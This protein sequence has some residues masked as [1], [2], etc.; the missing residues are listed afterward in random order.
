[1]KKN[2]RYQQAKKV[3]LYGALK[4]M[5]LGLMKVILGITGN[6]HALLADG[7]HSFSDLLTD[8]LVLAAS[9]W[10][11]QEAD[12]NHPYGH[13]RIET[14]ASM[15]LAL[16]LI[17]VGF[18]IA[19]DGIIRLWE[20][21]PHELPNLYV[22]IAALVSVLLNEGLFHYT[23]HI[24]EKIQSSLLLANAWHHRSDAASSFVVL[25]GVGAALLGYYQFDFAAAAIVGLMIVR[26]GAMLAWSSV[27]EL[28][29]TAV[30][31]EKLEQIHHTISNTSGVEAI[32]QLRTRS[33]GGEIFIDVH[34]LVN[35]RLSVTEGH[36]IAQR[37][38]FN[39]V[40]KVESVKDVIVHVDPE[41]D[42]FV[43]PSLK[44]PP[45]DKL[46]EIFHQR[47]L[48][49]NAENLPFKVVFHY[50]G[51]KVYMDVYFEPADQNEVLIM[52]EYE[53]KITLLLQDFEWLGGIQ[54]YWRGQK[55]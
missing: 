49:F 48:Q 19:Y 50:L 55:F 2:H 26:M 30:E 52:E 51:G 6:S 21:L 1:M 29:D 54:C 53:E 25:A 14:A 33:M 8:V 15:L 22:F 10:G 11:S 4:N 36:H 45:R 47:W 5:L 27:S 40:E 20:E 35:P 24:G 28:V 23:R 37:V 32:H 13:R 16:L 9:H 3:T 41:D 43:T 18:G 39:L 42:T 7:I 44:L 38:H 12:Q 17:L 46:L 34:I 31:A